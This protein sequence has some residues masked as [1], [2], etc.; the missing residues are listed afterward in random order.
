MLTTSRPPTA[1][2]IVA[3]LSLFADAIPA[4]ESAAVHLATP[5]DAIIGP[6]IWREDGFWCFRGI[7]QPRV[8]N[9]DLVRAAANAVELAARASSP[10]DQYLDLTGRPGSWAKLA[11]SGERMIS[12]GLPLFGG[13]MIAADADVPDEVIQQ[14]AADALSGAPSELPMIVD[15]PCG[16]LLVSGTP[17]MWNVVLVGAP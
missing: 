10:T 7:H 6:V 4:I 11:R 9:D 3:T 12:F 15:A 5:V 14:L 16:S 8:G 2:E 17:D 13:P 1:D